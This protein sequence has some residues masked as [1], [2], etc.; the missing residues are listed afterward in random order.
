[1]MAAAL[2][3]GE[4]RRVDLDRGQT[5]RIRLL[6]GQQTVELV[7]HD[8]ADPK[9]RLSTLVTAL[10]E[11]IHRP[12]EGTMF[13]SQEYTPLFR[14]LS[15]TGDRHDMLLEACNPALNQGLYGATDER[16]CWS[17][18]R[19]ALDEIGLPA[20]WVPYPLGLFRDAGDVDGRLALLQASS[21]EGD[22]VV[23]VGETALVVVVSACP[24]SAPA[25]ASARPT[26]EIEWGQA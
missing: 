9:V 18:F 22:E 20:K 14:I 15:Q 13:W 21:R 17:N 16:S 19:D 3:P 1:M 10:A 8:R 12:R 6:V 2:A 4:W 5:L 24:L 25:L 23:L 11:N 26:V 7:A